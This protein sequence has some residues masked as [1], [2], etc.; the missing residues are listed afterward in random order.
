M[1]DQDQPQQP[2]QPQPS[3]QPLQE[4]KPYTEFPR[5]DTR[6][7]IEKAD[8]PGTLLDKNLWPNK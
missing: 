3:Q 7:R 5:I 8:P 4:P 6:E 1:P 2:P